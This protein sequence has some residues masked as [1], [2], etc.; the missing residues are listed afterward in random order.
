M[1]QNL[2]GERRRFGGSTGNFGRAM[3]G[4]IDQQGP[5]AGRNHPP[6]NRSRGASAADNG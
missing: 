4:Q 6:C 5:Q 2:L 3:T 1:N